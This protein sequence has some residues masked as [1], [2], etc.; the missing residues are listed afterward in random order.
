MESCPKEGSIVSKYYSFSN[1]SFKTVLMK[2]Y[3][4]FL[5]NG[6]L[7]LLTCLFVSQSGGF[8]AFGALLIMNVLGFLLNLG[9]GLFYLVRGERVL[10]GVYLAVVIGLGLLYYAIGNSLQNHGGKMVNG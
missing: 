7:A 2:Y 3:I 6:G 4:P 5:L 9:L 1:P 10:G 8:A